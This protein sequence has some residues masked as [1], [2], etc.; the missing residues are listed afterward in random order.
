MKDDWRGWLQTILIPD[1]QSENIWWLPFKS[2]HPSLAPKH[3]RLW[4]LCHQFFSRNIFLEPN[5]LANQLFVA[6]C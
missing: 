2:S 6:L 3:W 5:K 4:L 1:W